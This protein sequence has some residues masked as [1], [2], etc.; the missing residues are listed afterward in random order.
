MYTKKKFCEG[1]KVQYGSRAEVIKNDVLHRCKHCSTS[2]KYKRCLELG[3]DLQTNLLKDTR[4]KVGKPYYGLLRCKVDAAVDGNHLRDGLYTFTEALPWI[5]KRNPR[6]FNGK[7]ISLTCKDVDSYRLN[8]KALKLDADF[9]VER[10]ALSV[11]NEICIA[12]GGL[13]E[14]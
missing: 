12:L 14:K 10:F 13:I 9:N 6:L 3:I 11:A 8:F 4:M 2:C 5:T 7:T 1:P